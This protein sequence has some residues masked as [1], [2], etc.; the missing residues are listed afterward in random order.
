MKIIILTIITRW[1]ISGS[2]NQFFRDKDSGYLLEVP[3]LIFLTLYLH[4]GLR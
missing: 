2:D 1:E 3:S 4:T